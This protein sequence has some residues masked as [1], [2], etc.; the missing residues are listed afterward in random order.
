MIK[1]YCVN[2]PDDFFKINKFIVLYIIYLSAL[3]ARDL[4]IVFLFKT[5][6]CLNII[7]HFFL[8]IDEIDENLISKSLN[9]A[10]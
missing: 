10:H 5:Y 1:T 6:K 7:P 2:L 8:S 3:K 4:R 9:K